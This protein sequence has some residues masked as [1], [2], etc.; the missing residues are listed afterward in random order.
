MPSEF[1]NIRYAKTKIPI[2]FPTVLSNEAMTSTEME[3][4]AGGRYKKS[5]LIVFYNGYVLGYW[6]HEDYEQARRKILQIQ[7]QNNQLPSFINKV[8]EISAEISKLL[9]EFNKTFSEATD[10]RATAWKTYDGAC[11][12]YRSLCTYAY[13]ANLLDRILTETVKEDLKQYIVDENKL[14][15]DLLVLSRAPKANYMY[16][17]D[18]ELIDLLE[19]QSTAEE[20]ENHINKWCG[21]FGGG[22]NPELEELKKEVAGRIVLFKGMTETQRIKERENISQNFLQADENIKKCETELNLTAEI[23]DKFKLFRDAIVLKEARKMALVK[24][25]VEA[26]FLFQAISDLT[27]ITIDKLRCMLPSETESL[28]TD[29]DCDISNEIDDNVIYVINGGIVV[30]YAGQDFFGKIKEYEIDEEVLK[31]KNE[32]S[33]PKETIKSIAP[34]LKKIY[35][36]MVS[37]RGQITAPVKVVMTIADFGKIQDGDILVTP[38]TTPEYVKIFHKVRGMITFDGAGLTS[39]PATLSREY[40]IPAILGVKELDGILKDGDMVELNADNNEIKIL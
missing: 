22:S 36:G 37:C 30:K 14:Q 12:L 23:K 29:K 24:F 26:N 11:N 32:L 19:K 21:L 3:E 18:L 4:I 9:I 39:H 38:L 27:G 16:Q 33:G 34:D 8:N 2:I 40:K 7:L 35:K 31:L 17:H 5:Q 28:L 15:D 10:K 1:F 20:M 25:S 13:V 6:H